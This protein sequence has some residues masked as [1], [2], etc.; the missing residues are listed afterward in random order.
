MRRIIGATGS[1]R[2]YSNEN[3]RR[4]G[5]STAMAADYTRFA[6][7]VTPRVTLPLRIREGLCQLRQEDQRQG[8]GNRTADAGGDLRKRH[9]LQAVRG[10][11]DR[12]V[13]SATLA[14]VARVDD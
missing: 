3:S 12:N 9:Q 7:V 6:L 10:S 2:P 13:A 11:Q 14:A 5:I 1:S 4:N 8:D